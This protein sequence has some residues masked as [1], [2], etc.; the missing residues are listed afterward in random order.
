MKY[1]LEIPL[2]TSL[3]NEML[4]TFLFFYELLTNAATLA[5]SATLFPEQRRH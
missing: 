4:E 2:P 1:A 5:G 3:S